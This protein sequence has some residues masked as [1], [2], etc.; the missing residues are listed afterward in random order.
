MKLISMTDFIIQQHEKCI[1]ST[2]RTYNYAM[3]LKQPLEL[4]MFIPCD[5]Y[6]NVLEEP[7]GDNYR[8]DEEK[9]IPNFDYLKYKIDSEKYQKAKERCLFEG[10]EISVGKEAIT[11]YKG[12]ILRIHGKY[13]FS[14]SGKQ[15]KIIEDLVKYNLQLTATAIKQ[16]GL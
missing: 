11:N 1:S 2:G 9:L 12:F 3:F 13:K 16:L 8:K 15:I 14:L 10:F 6:G 7:N 4:W 5:E